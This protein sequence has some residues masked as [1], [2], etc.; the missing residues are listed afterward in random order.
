MSPGGRI[1]LVGYAGGRAATLD[2]PTLIERDVS[3]LPVN[4]LRRRARTQE[5]DATVIGLLRDGDLHLPLT[6]FRLD[7]L[8]GAVESVSNGET[9]GRVVLV[10][11]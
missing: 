10:P 3:L 2:L 6:R 8:T 4:L 11:G 5:A 9:V 7:D 1:V